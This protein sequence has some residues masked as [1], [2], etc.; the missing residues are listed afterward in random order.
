MIPLGDGV[1]N[2]EQGEHDVFRDVGVCEGVGVV[3]SVSVCHDG[4]RPYSDWHLEKLAI[5]NQS[6][7]DKY[8][9]LC[10]K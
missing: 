5:I 2:F 10:N 8:L 3:E 6:T 9:C 7:G 4:A 1:A